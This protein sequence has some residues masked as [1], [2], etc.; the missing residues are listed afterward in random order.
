[1]ELLDNN[2][3][4]NGS[5]TSTTEFDKW[6]FDGSDDSDESETDLDSDASEFDQEEDESETS[7]TMSRRMSMSDDSLNSPPDETSEGFYPFPVPV[8]PVSLRG[9]MVQVAD[10]RR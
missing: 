8:S 9:A 2:F 3:T 1:M 6:N 4:V 10:L 7:E 5:Q